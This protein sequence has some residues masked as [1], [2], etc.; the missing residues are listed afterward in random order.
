M[1]TLV[2]AVNVVVTELGTIGKA[3]VIQPG[4]GI[5]W[6][7]QFAGH[8]QRI[9]A[10]R[11]RRVD[12]ER[13]LGRATNFGRCSDGDRSR[14]IERHMGEPSEDGFVSARLGLFARAAVAIR[15]DIVVAAIA[16]G[17]TA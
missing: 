7:R 8:V 3:G 10:K 9:I 16:I 17:A 15:R 13:S 11:F 6:R 2:V 1:I 4:S 14:L 12:V 5:V